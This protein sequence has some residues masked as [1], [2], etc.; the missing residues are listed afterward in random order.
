M[1]MMN[2]SVYQLQN[3]RKKYKL[4]VKKIV[5]LMITLWYTSIR[6]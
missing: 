5:T 2:T 4:N 3:F 1:Y 6:K